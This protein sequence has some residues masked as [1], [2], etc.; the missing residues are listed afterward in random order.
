MYARW[1]TVILNPAALTSVTRNKTLYR[2]HLCVT[3]RAEKSRRNRREAERE[4]EKKRMWRADKD[5]EGINQ[6]HQWRNVQD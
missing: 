2:I 1:L 5:A 4:R 3:T 6:N